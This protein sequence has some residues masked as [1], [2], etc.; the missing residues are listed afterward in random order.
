MSFDAAMFDLTAVAAWIAALI[1]V[2]RRPRRQWTYGRISQSLTALTVFWAWVGFGH[3]YLPVAALIVLRR[4]QQR[5][6]GYQ[7]RDVPE[8]RGWP[9]S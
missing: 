2:I 8:A 6:Q 1:V 7:D 4:H 9:G 5:R 3:Y